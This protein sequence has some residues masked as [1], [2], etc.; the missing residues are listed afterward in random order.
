[1]RFFWM[2]FL[3]TFFP[4]AAAVFGQE[5]CKAS[6][7]QWLERL[8]NQV[9]QGVQAPGRTKAADR[10]TGRRDED[11]SDR[12][13]VF[14]RAM[15]CIRDVSVNPRTKRAHAPS[16]S[17]TGSRPAGRSAYFTRPSLAKMKYSGWRLTISL[18]VSEEIPR[19]RAMPP[20]VRQSPFD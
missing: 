15:S 8:T 13:Y 18:T 12:S 11:R 9:L 5:R 7:G 19:S 17:D 14:R 20:G 10:Y 2:V 3:V 6:C 4:A 16:V 1:M